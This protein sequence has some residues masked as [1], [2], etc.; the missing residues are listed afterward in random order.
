LLI[1]ASLA[2]VTLPLIS[3]RLV[4]IPLAVSISIYDSKE[5]FRMLK[6]TFTSDPLTRRLGFSCECEIFIQ[7]L[8]RATPKLTFRTCALITTASSI[9]RIFFSAADPRAR[10]FR[11]IGVFHHFKFCCKNLP[12]YAINQRGQSN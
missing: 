10:T 4:I 8:L 6:K 9:W 7:N 12:S 3:T 11:I 1:R 5:M 2:S